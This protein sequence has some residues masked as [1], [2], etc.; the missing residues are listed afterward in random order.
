MIDLTATLEDT[1]TIHAIAKR[2]AVQLGSDLL[3]TSMDLTACHLHGCALRLTALLEADNFNFA[4]DV[5]G[6]AR[7]I[8]RETGEL[9][10]CFL[11]RYSA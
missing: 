5:L 6:I 1:H 7:H 8:D 4:H 11:P 2:A 9:R 3:T 10:D